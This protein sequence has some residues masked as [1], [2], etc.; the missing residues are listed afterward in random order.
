MVEITLTPKK[1]AFSPTIPIEAE[2]ISTDNFAVK[3]IDEIKKLQ[4]W[5]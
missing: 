5:E 4:V 2:I 1:E 3:S